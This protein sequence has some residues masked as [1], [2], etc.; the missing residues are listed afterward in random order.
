MTYK[1]FRAVGNRCAVILGCLGLHLSDS[2]ALEQLRLKGFKKVEV[3]LISLAR[4]CIGKSQFVR[5]A[6][7]CLAPEI[8]DCASFT[9]WL[10]AHLGIWLPRRSVQ[11]RDFGFPIELKYIVAN[12]LIFTTGIKNYNNGN[13]GH[14]I[15][16]VGIATGEGTI[17]HA[18]S[19][20]LGIIESPIESFVIEVKFR[21]IRR[22][23]PKGLP[24]I[25]FEIPPEIEVETSDDIKWLLMPAS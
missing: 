20:E 8:I 14:R 25:T 3:D 6:K 19:K 24:V 15:G 12:D 2:E 23:L 4:Q 17:V 16:H 1:I 22:Y 21:G 5:G 10:Y 11:Q 9:K 7:M 13:D 18:A